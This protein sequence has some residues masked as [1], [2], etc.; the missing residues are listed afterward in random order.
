MFVITGG[1]GTCARGRYSSLQGGGEGGGKCAKR[2]K[3]NISLG[4]QLRSE[5]GGE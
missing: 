2:K 4:V 3:K 1:C 5:K